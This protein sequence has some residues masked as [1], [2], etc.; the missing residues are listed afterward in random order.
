MMEHMAKEIEFLKEDVD[1][2]AFLKSELRNENNDLRNDIRDSDEQIRILEIIASLASDYIHMCDKYFWS[3]TWSAIQTPPAASASSR[4]Q[5][6]EGEMTFA[7]DGAMS[8]RHSQV[9]GLVA[10]RR[11]RAAASSTE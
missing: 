4:Q 9:L 6:I 10:L 8:K 3:S 1:S 2:L 5:E 7:Y 11:E